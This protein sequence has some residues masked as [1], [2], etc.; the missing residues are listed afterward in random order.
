MKIKLLLLITCLLGYAIALNAME[1]PSKHFKKRLA[2]E[3]AASEEEYS[4]ARKAYLEYIA[5]KRLGA[6]EDYPESFKKYRGE[7]EELSPITERRY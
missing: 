5:R 1:E 7:E 6:A 3:G 2:I 4:P